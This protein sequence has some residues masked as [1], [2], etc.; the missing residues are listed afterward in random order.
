[1]SFRILRSVKIEM[2]R[3]INFSFRIPTEILFE[4]S[5]LVKSRRYK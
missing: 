4:L 2:W 5:L 1:M 3:L